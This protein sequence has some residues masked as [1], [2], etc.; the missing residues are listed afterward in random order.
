VRVFYSG[1]E[2]LKEL[3]FQQYLEALAEEAKTNKR[4]W[5]AFEVYAGAFA[6]QWQN[7]TNGL[8]ENLRYRRKPRTIQRTI[9]LPV[10]LSEVQS[11]QLLWAPNLTTDACSLLFRRHNAC[12]VALLRAG[13]LYATKEEA[14]AAT[15]AI[16]GV[17]DE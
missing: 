7:A 9:T 17:G 6:N 2:A 1:G 3:N 4:P 10:G 12:N 15:D 8:Y 5:E 13:L 14:I 16:L 11:G